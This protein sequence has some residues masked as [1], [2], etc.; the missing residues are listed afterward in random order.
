MYSRTIEVYTII[1]VIG[2]ALTVHDYSLV[3]YQT[4]T[5]GDWDCVPS[6]NSLPPRSPGAAQVCVY[7][8][9]NSSCTDARKPS[10]IFMHNL[11]LPWSANFS[12]PE[13]FGLSRMLCSPD[14]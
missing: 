9:S 13:E 3:I 8:A 5:C 4:R 1:F 2:R 6:R 12:R 11:K 14:P 7:E 10:V